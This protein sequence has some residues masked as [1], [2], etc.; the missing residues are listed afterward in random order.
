MYPVS[1]RRRAL[2]AAACLVLTAGL[3]AG[4]G[5]MLARMSEVGR[6][7]AMTT[8]QNPTQSPVY[9]PV[10]MP[11]PQTLAVKPHANS[12]WRPG[13]RAFFKDQR[14]SRV[15]DILTV[16]ISID[17]SAEIENQTT[18]SRT[19]GADASVSSLLGYESS[20]SRVLPEAINP[21]SLID[22]DS[23]S[24]HAGAGTVERG[25]TIKLKVAAVVT[26]R[27]PNGNLVVHGR[28]E[29]RVNFEVRQ[30][31]IAGVIRP[32]DIKADNTLSYEK[33]AEARISY[34]G[35]GQ[36][37][38]VQQPGWGQQIYDIVWPF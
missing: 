18:R 10:S 25:E 30:L 28:Q 14:A 33:I 15:G 26:Q 29:V 8:I 9:R 13:A 7:P 22:F 32:E 1:G 5:D 12:L 27:L 17:D 37:T 36:I 2:P 34:G 31:Q 16:L 23:Q 21:G 24:T 11:M 4:C 38:D 20:L 35:R 6:A 19:N 3:L